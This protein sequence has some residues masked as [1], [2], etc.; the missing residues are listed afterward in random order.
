MIENSPKFNA[1]P[2]ERQIMIMYTFLLPKCAAQYKAFYADTSKC[3]VRCLGT[4]PSPEAIQNY[5][6][7]QAEERAKGRASNIFTIRV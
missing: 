6:N 7:A 2:K 4:C 5:V 3:K 1:L